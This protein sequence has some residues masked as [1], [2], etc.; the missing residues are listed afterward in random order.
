MGRGINWGDIE[1]SL[2]GWVEIMKEETEA[3]GNLGDMEEKIRGIMREIGREVLEYTVQEREKIEIDQIRCERC[4]GEIKRNGKV[5]RKIKTMLGEIE[6]ER[7]RVRCKSCGWD[8]FPS[9]QGARD[10][11]G[12]GD[13]P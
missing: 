11:E 12:E 8:F 13:K 5:R 9:G 3:E 6:I 7:P 1:K 2:R 10:R 4:G